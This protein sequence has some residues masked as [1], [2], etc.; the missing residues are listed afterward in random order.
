MP[1]HTRLT[2]RLRIEQPI[3]LA[4]MASVSGGRLAA[5]VSNSGGL[6]LIAGGLG[7]RAFLASEFAAA[8]SARVGCG[9]ITW[10]LANKRHLLEEVLRTHQPVA[11]LLS[12][13][14]PMPY[15]SAIHAANSLMICQVQ[16]MTQT[17]RALDAGADIL[18]AQGAEAGGHGITRATMTLV[19]EIAD[20]LAR[21]TRDTLLIAAGGIADGRGLAAALMLGADGVMMGSRFWASEEC[22]VH[23]HHKRAALMRDGDGTVRTTIGDLA[24][25]SAWPAEYTARALRTAYVARWHGRE[26]ELRATAAETRA[27]FQIAMAEGRTE[28]VEIRVG[29]AIGLM[30]EVRPAADIIAAIVR[31]AVALLQTATT[32][33]LV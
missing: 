30:Q 14:D 12:F 20:L 29:E 2:K 21:E 4:P 32:R 26:S 1:I 11:T 22:L 18:V 7:D 33:Y 31:E 9:F 10:A 25:G 5:A 27:A 6:G 23:A 17:R 13:G 16:N 28:D 8:S 19:P 24:R 15:A 3:L